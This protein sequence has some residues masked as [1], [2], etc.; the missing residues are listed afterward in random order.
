MLG[1]YFIPKDL[2]SEIYL[3]KKGLRKPCK[4]NNCSHKCMFKAFL[5]HCLC[6]KSRKS[7]ILF[8]IFFSNLT[9]DFLTNCSHKFICCVSMLP[10]NF[11]YLDDLSLNSFAFTVILDGLYLFIL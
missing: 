7:H 6:Y 8:L 1:Q 11:S 5:R 9:F 2:L 4:A 10:S 3:S